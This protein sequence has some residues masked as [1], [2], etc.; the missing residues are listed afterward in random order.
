MAIWGIIIYRIFH[1]VNGSEK[2]QFNDG[3]KILTA[4]SGVSL[5][6]T[7][8]ININYR[9][10]FDYVETK[11][12]SEIA[13]ASTTL[14]QASSQ[15]KKSAPTVTVKANLAWPLIEF[16]GI[17]KNNGANK[18]L[19]LIQINGSSTIMKQG[20]LKESIELIKLTKDSI[21]VKFQTETK[22][23]RK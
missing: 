10:P 17:I 18:Q 13:K 14:I 23:I 2:K 5:P 15:E 12:S 1:V 16:M 9:N 6:D 19:A 3:N 4:D 8:S 11:H 20:D 22:W 7:F 21:A